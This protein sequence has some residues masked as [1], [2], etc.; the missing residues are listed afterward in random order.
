MT[1]DA[2]RIGTGRIAPPRRSTKYAMMRGE[3]KNVSADAAR[4]SAPVRVAVS[5]GVF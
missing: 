5:M 4:T 3:A 2:S 1:A